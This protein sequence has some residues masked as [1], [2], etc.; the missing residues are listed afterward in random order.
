MFEEVRDRNGGRTFEP[1][2]RL[3]FRESSVNRIPLPIGSPRPEHLPPACRLAPLQPPL[4]RRAS[5]RGFTLTELLMVVVLIGLIAVVATPGFKNVMRD[6]RVNKAGMSI[7][8][9]Y[10]VARTRALGRGAAMLVRWDASKNSKGLLSVREAIQGG[11]KKVLPGSSCFTTDWATSSPTSRL[12]SEFPPPSDGYLYDL[13]SFKY[14][15]P[16]GTEKPF[17]ELCFTPRGRTFVR[18]DASDPFVPL[19]GVPRFEV[20]NGLTGVVRTVFAPPNGVAR[21]AL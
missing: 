1:G 4:R 3:A 7:A 6:S 10:R 9:A 13:A 14:F 8:E 5:V 2:M 18:H 20:K 12:V 21:L 15:D 16:S 19:T 17:S 11:T